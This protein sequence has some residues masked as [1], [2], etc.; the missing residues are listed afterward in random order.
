M[1]FKLTNTEKIQATQIDTQYNDQT[2]PKQAE[3]PLSMIM[4]IV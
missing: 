2:E 3:F 1:N 4:L